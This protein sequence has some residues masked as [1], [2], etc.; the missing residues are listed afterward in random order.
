MILKKAKNVEISTQ[1]TLGI[2]EKEFDNNN[3]NISRET[4]NNGQINGTIVKE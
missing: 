2:L 3:E 4:F 1:R